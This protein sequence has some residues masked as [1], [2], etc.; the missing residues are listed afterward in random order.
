MK[1]MVRSMV[2]WNDGERVLSGKVKQV[3]LD[4]V[5]V[6]TTKGDFIVR[7]A[8]IQPVEKKK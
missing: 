6:E 5:L 7:K 4:H 2:Q 3:M 1:I 8:I